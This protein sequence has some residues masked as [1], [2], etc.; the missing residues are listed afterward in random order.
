MHLLLEGSDLGDLLA[1][2]RTQHGPAARV[3]R[4]ERIRSGGVAGFFSKERY[5][6]TVEMDGAGGDDETHVSHAD[7][8]APDQAPAAAG[9][10]PE[11]LQVEE[12]EALDFEA[13]LAA[14]DAAETAASAAPAP[15]AAE[16]TVA[17][18]EFES[19]RAGLLEVLRAS[20]QGASA[21]APQAALKESAAD[22]EDRG[23]IAQTGDDQHAAST[24]LA[25]LDEL[26]A[27][28]TE[29]DDQVRKVGK[30]GQVGHV[31]QAD[32][33]DEVVEALAAD[34]AAV[35]AFEAELLE[36]ARAE[37]EREELE[38][39]QVERARQERAELER[40]ELERA[41]AERAEAQRAAARAAAERALEEERMQQ[42]EMERREAE[43][44]EHARREAVR[45]Q[46]VRREAA[47]A[48]VRRRQAE[49]VSAPRPQAQGQ[50]RAHV[51]AQA[52]ARSLGE[53]LAAADA[54]DGTDRLGAMFAAGQG[55]RRR[56]S[57]RPARTGRS[58]PRATP[59]PGHWP[60]CVRAPREP[61]RLE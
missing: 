38:R 29:Q 27:E 43:R 7:D 48:D 17:A 37:I 55:S 3:V 61:L 22:A 44:A 28:A 33:G 56:S 9:Q 53:V 58:R 54:A 34:E 26:V 21:D 32:H 24:D 59:S 42:L 6:V 30:V 12:R 45:E 50:A 52:P 2:V 10:A 8:Q 19:A 49:R 31:D 16:D 5:E 11:G 47:R 35:A 40:A 20:Q 15:V 13:L 51:P 25:H 46:E 41:E 39:A 1:E 57:G 60:R 14:A 18:E 36:Q 23:V 4:A